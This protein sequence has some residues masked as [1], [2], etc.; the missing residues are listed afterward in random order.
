MSHIGEGTC[1]YGAGCYIIQWGKHL[2]LFYIQ[3]MQA[4][5]RVEEIGEEEWKELVKFSYAEAEGLGRRGLTKEELEE[6]LF[7]ST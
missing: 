6:A 7:P 3:N 2:T 1:G 5:C 4:N